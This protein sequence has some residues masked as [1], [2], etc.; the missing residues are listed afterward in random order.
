MV[1]LMDSTITN[2]YTYATCAFH[3]GVTDLIHNSLFLQVFAGPILSASKRFAGFVKQIYSMEVI[4]FLITC[5][6]WAPSEP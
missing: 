3:H 6:N 4:F 1:S 2:Y 5:E